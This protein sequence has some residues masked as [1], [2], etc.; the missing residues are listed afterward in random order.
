M[1]ACGAM[2]AVPPFACKT[3]SSTRSAE[4]STFGERLTVTRWRWRRVVAGVPNPIKVQT[5][6]RTFGGPPWHPCGVD[7]LVMGVDWYLFTESAALVRASLT[8]LNPPRANFAPSTPL[9]SRVVSHRS[10]GNSL[11]RPRLFLKGSSTRSTRTSVSA[12]LPR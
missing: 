6:M 10:S 8:G 1:L 5:P 2:E 11:E 7:T 12:S 9:P 4:R 3:S